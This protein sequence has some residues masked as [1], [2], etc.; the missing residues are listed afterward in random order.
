MGETKDGSAIIAD[1]P[2]LQLRVVATLF[3]H[4]AITTAIQFSYA[5]IIAEPS[6]VAT[7]V[8]VLSG[9]AYLG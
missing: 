7:W 1:M 6:L 3:S 2:Q 9:H 5:A 4:T 8:A